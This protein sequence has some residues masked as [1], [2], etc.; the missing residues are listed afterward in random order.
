MSTKISPEIVIEGLRKSYSRGA[1]TV[2][3]FEGLDLKFAAGDFVALMGPS[4]SGKST[5]LNVVGGLDR[6]DSGRVRVGDTDVTSLRGDALS[7]W[8][9]RHVGFIFQAFNLIPVLT[10]KENVELPL[11]L[12]PLNAKQRSEQADYA[13]EIVGLADRA[14]H[15]PSALSGG[16]EQRVAIAR[17]IATDP[18]VILADEPTGDLDRQSAD[19][20]LELLARLSKDLGKTVLMV[21][22]DPAAAAFARQTL[23]LE[24]GIFVERSAT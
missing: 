20:V 17:A 4:G 3:V 22:H 21:T 8:R 14:K 5:L 7:A 10:A 19:A 11:L 1:E 12:Q 2:D 16:Q 13:L 23:Y 9:S 15:R 6:A 18:D 24:K